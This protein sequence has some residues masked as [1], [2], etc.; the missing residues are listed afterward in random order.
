M[1]DTRFW[2]DDYI[3][4]L[5]PIEKLLFNYLLTNSLTSISGIY[6]L[7]LRTIAFHTGIDKEMLIKIFKRFDKD[8]KILTRNPWVCVVNYPK[9][10]NYESEQIQKAVLKEFSLVPEPFFNDFI[11]N[12]YIPPI[13]PLVGVYRPSKG[14]GKGKGKE[15]DKD[16]EGIRNR[17]FQKPSIEEIQIY[18]I[19]RKN[20]ID[21]QAFY[22]FYESVGWKVGNK[23]MKNWQAAVRTWEKRDNIKKSAKNDLY[24]V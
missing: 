12:G 21:P 19:E 6:E 15:Q 24:V 9:Y 13:D 2:D 20:A 4:E 23:P 1:F 17:I 16:K 22:D 10:Q 5:D 18:C 7:P 8:K 3:L 14:K 11:S